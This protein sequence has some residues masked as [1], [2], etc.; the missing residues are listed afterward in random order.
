[1]TGKILSVVDLAG[2]HFL[3][4]VVAVFTRFYRP[5]GRRNIEPYVRLRIVLQYAPT[6]CY[7]GCAGDAVPAPPSLW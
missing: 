4:N 1:M 6:L 3:G 7:A 5:L 2:R